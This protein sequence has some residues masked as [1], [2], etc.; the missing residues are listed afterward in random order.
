MA[1]QFY[2]GRIHKDNLIKCNANSTFT[3]VAGAFDLGTMEL[4]WNECKYAIFPNT[5]FFIKDTETD[6]VWSFVISEDNVEVVKKTNPVR[7]L[8]KLTISQDIHAINNVPLRNT[9]FT[10]PF[11]SYKKIKKGFPFVGYAEYEDTAFTRIIP[12][13]SVQTNYNSATYL[14]NNYVYD[15]TQVN[16]FSSATI[17]VKSILCT[18]N[19][20]W[21]ETGDVNFASE[22]LTK[23]NNKYI[24]QINLKLFKYGDSG[25]YRDITIRADQLDKEIVLDDWVLL[26]LQ[27][28]KFCIQLS[29]VGLDT[30]YLNQYMPNYDSV[31]GTNY[32]PRICGFVNA[33]FSFDTFRYTL[34]DVLDTINKQ[35]KKHYNNQEL[36]NF[37]LMPSKI[38][39]G[40]G[41][42]LAETPAPEFE[43]TNAD[44]YEAVAKVMS[45]IDA[46]PVLKT[47][48]TLD[49]QYLNDLSKEEVSDIEFN[50]IKTTR[51]ETNFTN[52]LASYYQ[53]GK[54]SNPICF[55]CKN[56]FKGTTTS[57]YG[58]PD[59][60]D[61][62]FEVP[63]K[64][65]YID[66]LTVM[67][68]GGYANKIVPPIFEV[69]DYP[70]APLGSRMLVQFEQVFVASYSDFSSIND[71]HR[72]DPIDID[73]TS[74]LFRNDI[75]GYL[76][77]GF[78]DSNYQ[79]KYN[80]LHYEKNSKLIYLG[81]TAEVT[82]TPNI[83]AEIFKY[84]L[85]R[86]AAY[87]FGFGMND[88]TLLGIRTKVEYVFNCE[89]HPIL[90]GKVSQES[91][92]NKTEKETIVS[93][94][95][96]GIQLE[97]L[98]NNLQG[99]I[100]K[101]GNEEKAITLPITKLKDK[102]ALG[103]KI[104]DDLGDAWIVNKIQITFLTNKSKV[105]VNATIVKN[106]NALAQFTQLNQEKRFY[107]ISDS[108]TTKGYDN[109]NE[110]IY[111]SNNKNISYSQITGL[112]T[113]IAITSLGM[114]AI[115]H[116]T[117]G[118]SPSELNGLNSVFE[119][120]G[121]KADS[122]ASEIMTYIQPTVYGN[123]NQIC[124]EMGF[125]SST[126]N[127]N[128]T[129]GTTSWITQAVLYTEEEGECQTFSLVANF[130]NPSQV[131]YALDYPKVT[132]GYNDFPIAYRI[133]NIHG[134]D[135]FKKPNEIFHLNYA[136]NFLPYWEKQDKNI[137][138]NI[139]LPV[140][141]YEEI[142][143]GDKFI[144]ENGI[145]SETNYENGKSRQFKFFVSDE[146]F[147][148][149]DNK[150][151]GTE[152]T[153]TITIQNIMDFDETTSDSNGSKSAGIINILANNNSIDVSQYNSWCLCDGDNNILIAVNRNKDNSFNDAKLQWFT[154]RNR[155]M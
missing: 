75:Y 94:S 115:I 61:W 71:P 144:N 113:R 39:G 17:K 138:E 114:R 62:Y 99:L 109:I 19:N 28:K 84:A 134:Y 141:K 69:S 29:F 24:T 13:A 46:F 47:D 103:T 15:F 111:F 148:L 91:V 125:D 81:E 22:Q 110:F 72:T 126:L 89:F 120:A 23:F 67:L 32:R 123:G 8:H 37:Y 58:V 106:Y 33:E 140:Y 40:H 49:F 25:D 153:G 88:N 51:T 108:L 129:N 127:G 121:I 92:A 53:N 128:F 104:I 105:I 59:R 145:I 131:L 68:V 133:M 152:I 76:P 18:F 50:D 54:I 26:W 83:T 56:G 116:K 38:D 41:Q 7:Y 97:R 34:W 52:K 80:S 102:I 124:F 27:N 60:N 12:S 16:G 4:E 78:A 101:L 132:N 3:E 87:Q 66:K 42:L 143:F 146:K 35:C 14:Q 149:I 21:M 20:W 64:I 5:K 112:A 36:D 74:V 65:D 6:E 137:T 43:F 31:S 82:S 44:L 122:Y 154:S 11:G 86:A 45:Y 85:F 10:Q 63:K 118:N 95:S 107:E 48:G 77:N 100:A 30:Q 9:S 98:G 57:R 130:R 135:Y 70:Y 150:P 55:P 93:Q 96:S 2:L 139:T 136:L 119:W 147:S 117:F 73:L 1:I 90:D 151:Q 79:N 155:K 142:F